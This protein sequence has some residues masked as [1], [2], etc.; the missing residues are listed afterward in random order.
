M[1]FRR[2]IYIV[3]IRQAYCLRMFLLKAATSYQ[4][5]TNRKQVILYSC[6]SNTD[7][8]MKERLGDYLIKN[9]KMLE[10]PGI[11]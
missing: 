5:V 2:Y 3:L 11:S 8:E 7:C 10:T 6:S 1:I 4:T 9:I